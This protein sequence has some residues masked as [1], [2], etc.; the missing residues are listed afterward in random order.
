MF[1]EANCVPEDIPINVCT[2]ESCYHIVAQLNSDCGNA[3]L[4]KSA[5][6]ESRLWKT[7]LLQ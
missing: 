6:Q 2:V 7:I 4:P 5:D 3:G 1:V